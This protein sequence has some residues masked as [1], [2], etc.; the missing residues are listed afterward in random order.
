MSLC[1]FN[2]Q[3]EPASYSWKQTVGLGIIYI[4]VL[5]KYSLAL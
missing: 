1:I 3:L 2:E 4:I 5:L